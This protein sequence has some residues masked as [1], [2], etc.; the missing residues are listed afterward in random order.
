MLKD[1]AVQVVHEEIGT[2]AAAVAV[3]DGEVGTVRPLLL[4]PRG[5]TFDVDDDGDTVFVVGAN[6]SVG[7]I[8]RVVR[9]GGVEL[10]GGRLRVR[11]CDRFLHH[12]TIEQQELTLV[13]FCLQLR[14]SSQSGA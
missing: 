12:T 3:E 4:F 8:D 10:E 2:R 1:D 5:L 6:E 14:V 9:R 7:S 11:Q 13:V